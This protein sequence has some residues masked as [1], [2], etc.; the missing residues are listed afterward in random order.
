[1]DAIHELL[2]LERLPPADELRQ[3]FDPLARLAEL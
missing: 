2:R 3:S 1:M